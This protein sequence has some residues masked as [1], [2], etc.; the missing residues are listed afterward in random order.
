[1]NV[2]FDDEADWSLLSPAEFPIWCHFF[3]QTWSIG[4]VPVDNL[5]LLIDYLRLLI[6]WSI[7]W[8]NV[9]RGS[10]S[11]SWKV[12][13]FWVPLDGGQWMSPGGNNRSMN[14]RKILR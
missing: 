10:G 1:M 7:R 2:M 12:D 3:G 9:S 5:Y 4:S 8:A 6:V 13:A 11:N 14:A